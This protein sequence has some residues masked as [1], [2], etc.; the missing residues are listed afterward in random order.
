[1]LFAFAAFAIAACDGGGGGQPDAAA[2]AGTDAPFVI[3]SHAPMP[4]AV[5][6]GGAV[7]AAPKMVAIS[8]QGDSLQAAIDAFATQMQANQAYWS[9]ATGEYGVGPLKSVTF[10]STDTP[11]ASLTDGDVQTWLGNKIQNDVTFPKPDA[12]TI[13][14]LF[15]PSGVNVTALGGGV[16]CMQFQGYHD[17]FVAGS[18]NVIYAVV[19]RCPAPPVAGVTDTDQMTAEASH[20]LAEAATDPMPSSLKPGYLTVDANSHAWE[21]LAGGEIGDLCA[22]FPDSFYKPIGFDH[23]VQHIW[24]NAAAAASHDPCQPQGDV[25]YFNSAPAFTDTVT[26]N[27][28]GQNLKTQGVKLL[29]GNSATI[30]LDLYSDAPTS[31]P[32]TVSAFDIT[33]QFF[34]GS[35]ALSFSFDKNTGQNGD[36]INLTIKS[37]MNVAGGA[38]FWIESDLGPSSGALFSCQLPACVATVWLG[39]V[40]SN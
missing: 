7:L 40:S 6:G 34:G 12:N 23:L 3:A 28:F 38:P 27:I 4:Q 37:L 18:A 36:K 11:A 20:E 24:S 2:D 33:S 22:A 17:S 21:L 30:E 35:P 19:P 8:F 29:N 32:W 26:L 39:A 25:P 15:Y 9:G 16:T 1:L 14:T 5:S 31:G 13:Y 10:H